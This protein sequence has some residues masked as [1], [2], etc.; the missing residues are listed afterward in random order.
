MKT[1]EQIA[2]ALYPDYAAGGGIREAA[3]AGARAAQTLDFAPE[4]EPDD[5]RDDYEEILGTITRVV[6]YNDEMQTSAEYEVDMDGR[7]IL[8]LLSNEARS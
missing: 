8:V 7:S 1:P 5:Y 4:G 2:E 3:V 6:L